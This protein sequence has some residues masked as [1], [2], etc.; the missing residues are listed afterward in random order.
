MK[1]EP[2]ANTQLSDLHGT[3]K[4]DKTQIKPGEPIT[5]TYEVT[6]TGKTE[7]TVRFSSGQRFD[8]IVTQNGKTVYQ[9]GRE[10]MYTMSLGQIVLAP[11][12]TQA[13]TET[14]KPDAGNI[15]ADVSLRAEAFLTPMKTA[16]GGETVLPHPAS[17]VL[18]FGA[19][20]SAPA[21][22]AK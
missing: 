16:S 5:F 6:N 4:A 12:K 10:K 3:L 15:K 17:A 19:I 22:M 8:I 18:L 21:K 20:G 13:F 2:P 14:W 9:M 11:G 1:T 7:Q